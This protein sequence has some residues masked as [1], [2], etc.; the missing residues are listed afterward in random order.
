LRGPAVRR[1]WVAG[2]GR[3]ELLGCVSAG[4]LRAG[5]EAGDV[6]SI[7]YPL[8]VVTILGVCTSSVLG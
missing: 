5:E 1:V 6:L 4:T 7:V 3:M 2:I 8:L